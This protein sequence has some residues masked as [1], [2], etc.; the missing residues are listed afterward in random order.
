MRPC[1][2]WKLFES[3]RSSSSAGIARET[4]PLGGRIR[5][6]RRY[7]HLT[8]Q[9]ALKRKFP[10]SEAQEIIAR[11][12]GFESWAALKA[13]IENTTLPPKPGVAAPEIR[14]AIPVVFVSSVQDTA[15]FFRDQLGFSADFLHGDPPF[16]GGISRNGVSLHLRFVHEPVVTQELREKELLLAALIA[17]KNVKGLFEEYKAKNVP[18]VGTLRREPWGG[19]AFTVRDPDGNWICFCEV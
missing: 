1:L 18:F 19:P 15:A 6:L 10:L 14:T 11:E 2:D 16:Y 7:A 4:I 12:A 17:V 8:D 13:E 5:G 3:K 9:E